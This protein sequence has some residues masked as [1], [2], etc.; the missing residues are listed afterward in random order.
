MIEINDFRKLLKFKEF[1]L[2]SF[3][4]IKKIY[5]V[6]KGDSVLIWCDTGSQKEKVSPRLGKTFYAEFK[7]MGCD[8]SL[9]VG[10]KRS[11]MGPASKIVTK[12]VLSL[13]KKD[14]FVSVGSTG[15]GHIIRNG[16][17]ISFRKLMGSKNFKVFSCSGL[18]G[19]KEKNIDA[20]FSSFEHD[21]GE[22]NLLHKKLVPLFK[23]ASLV[24]IACPLGTNVEF[25]FSHREVLSNDGNWRKYSTNYPIGEVYTTPMEDS[26]NG[27]AFVS[28]FRIIG[29]TVL[30]KKAVKFVF[31]KGLL[32]DSS[33]RVV[34]KNL[35]ELV[36]YNKKKKIKNYKDAPRTIAEFGIGTNRK[37]KIVG[38]MICDEKALGTC[39][40][41]IGDNKQYGG[42][43]YCFGH[44]DNVIASPTVWFDGRK[45]IE[46]GRLL[47]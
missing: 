42:K 32:V 25:R 27:I 10:K 18:S 40:F 43:N 14:L 15:P 37:A 28:S 11:R 45:I 17:H 44:F 6:R 46:N 26:A 19:L 39:H 16:A 21:Q 33:S 35:Q 41:A 47:V 1:P 8:V 31:K 23:E 24:K 7:K 29:G 38:A 20:F 4:K 9:I 5:G 36:D 13:E 2:H 22:I 30:P 3:K 34:K 12:A